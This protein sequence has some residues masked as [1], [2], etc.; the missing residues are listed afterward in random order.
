MA[1]DLCYSIDSDIKHTLMKAPISYTSEQEIKKKIMN[2][3]KKVQ[4]REKEIE[5]KEEEVK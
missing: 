4:A 5:Y 1:K 2:A 3:V